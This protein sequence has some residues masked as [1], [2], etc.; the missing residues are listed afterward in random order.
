MKKSNY[1]L[2]LLAFAILGTT[3]L[4]SCAHNAAAPMASVAADTARPEADRARDADRKP[5]EM[6]R[7][8]KVR[9]GQTVIDLM[10]GGGYFTRVFSSAVGPNGH[11]YAVNA[12]FYL[13]LLA[14]NNRPAPAPLA[15]GAGRTNIYDVITNEGGLNVPVKADLVWTSQN[16]HDVHLFADAGAVAALNRAAFDALKPGGYYVVL[17]HA[18]AAGLNAADMRRLHRIDEAQVRNE[19]LAAG[20]VLD[21]T[22][23]ALR[24]PADPRTA[25]VFDPAIRGKTDQ[26]ILRFKKPMR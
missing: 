8:A 12:R 13:D 22:S 5:D 10:A 21:G 14:R 7:F 24:N 9:P 18:G 15:G 17:D 6:L 1:V 19:V 16:Y 23:D 3:A 26:F 2:P 25:N 4:A 11:V 20:F